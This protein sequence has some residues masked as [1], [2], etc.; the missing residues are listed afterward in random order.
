MEKN[1]GYITSG[2]ITKGKS[3]LMET[4]QIG[5]L[6]PYL[7]SQFGGQV[8]AMAAMVDGLAAQP[9]SVSVFS[10]SR[11][12]EGKRV[13][14]IRSIHVSDFHDLSWGSFRHS[15]NLWR[16]LDKAKFALL[17]SHGLWTDVHRLAATMAYRKGVPHVLGTCGMLEPKALRRSWWKK[18]L[19]SLWFQQRALKEANCLLANSEHEYTDIRQYG[20]TNPVAILPNPI[21]GPETITTVL[22]EDIFRQYPVFAQKKTVLYLGRIHPVKGLARLVSAWAKLSSFHERWQLV[23]AGP[24]EGG[25][26]GEIEFQAEKLDC[27]S[28]VHFIGSLDESWKWGVLQASDLFVMP[29]NFENF[30]MSIAEAMLTGRPVITTMGTPWSILAEQNAGWWIASDTQILRKTLSH[31]MEL[32]DQE[33]QAM[34]KRGRAIVTKFSPDKISGQLTSLYS[35]LL[36]KGDRPAFVRTY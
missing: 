34:G 2:N 9:C 26:K 5:H 11:K 17:H 20:L 21:A 33:L 31:A 16:T 15:S 24:D 6:I 1:L 3:C 25:Y 32:S 14:L 29:S 13:D 7:S 10:V 22:R 35:W 12:N 18:R 30:G 36:K 19:V 28:S 4:I 23:L 8:T 27:L